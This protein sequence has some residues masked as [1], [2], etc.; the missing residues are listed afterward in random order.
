[1]AADKRVAVAREQERFEGSKKT[2]KYA[3]V[4]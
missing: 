4:I 3:N 2:R 1:M